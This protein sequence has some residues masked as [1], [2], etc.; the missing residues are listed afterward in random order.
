MIT[1]VNLVRLSFLVLLVGAWGLSTRMGAVSPLVL[2]DL[3]S[4]LSSFYAMLWT[5]DFW[6]DVRRTVFEVVLSSVI[7][8]AAGFLTGSVCW[9]WPR[10]GA[11][12]TPYLA[13]LYAMPT[14]A[15]YPILLALMGLTPWPIITIAAIMVF[16]PVAL[17]TT[18]GLNAVDQIVLKM[19]RS[20]H[21]N[22]LSMVTKILLPASAPL[23][24]PGIR[25]GVM[26]GVTATIA[27]EF[28][29]SSSG[30]GYR[31]NH[32]YDLFDIPAMWAGIVTVIM[33]AVSIMGALEFIERRLRSDLT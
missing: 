31:I 22:G 24:F 19:A 17:N 5:A 21:C 30:I 25:L 14:I 1:N 15:F 4:V 20:V 27:S 28:I 8:V 6:N 32:N 9:V 23:V 16:V 12:V 2:P 7:G 33:F 11:I 10:V 3:G 13:A 18:V 26:Y 29:L